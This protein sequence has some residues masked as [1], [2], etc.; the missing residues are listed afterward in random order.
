MQLSL[1]ET[2]VKLVKEHDPELYAVLENQTP[3]ESGS[4]L[5]MVYQVQGPD[6]LAINMLLDSLD[7]Y[8]EHE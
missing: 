4:G 8:P 3:V 7:E 6:W 5:W 1:T 2:E